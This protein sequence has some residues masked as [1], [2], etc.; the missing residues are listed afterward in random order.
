VNA[1]L[2]A[3]AIPTPTHRDML[4]PLAALLACMVTALFAP[5]LAARWWPWRRP[6][7]AI[8]GVCWNCGYSLRGLPGPVCPECG[9]DTSVVRTARPVMSRWSGV[10]VTCACWVVAVLVLAHFYEGPIERWLLRVM[11]GEDSFSMTMSMSYGEY[12]QA[13][14]LRR[15]LVWG[16][17]VVG[18][19]ILMCWSVVRHNGRESDVAARTGGR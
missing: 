16:V 17:V 9:C 7:R 18:L 11:T 15:L 14:H 19:A 12:A 6:W 5:R 13:Q 1:L 10:F 3:V 4:I 2:A 8:E